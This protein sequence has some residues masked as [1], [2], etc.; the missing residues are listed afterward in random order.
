MSGTIYTIGHSTRTIAE[1]IA[2]LQQ[3]DVN[4][5]VD[6]R[7]FPRS[8]A[9]PQFN[10]DTLPDALAVEGIGYQHLRALG[11]RRHHPR[12][13]PS[14]KN[15]YWRVAAF[16]NYADYAETD[17]FRSGLDELLALAD[18]HRCA[19]MCAEAVWWRCHRR[20]ITDYLLAGS[21]PVE[22]IMGP[23]NVT[24][25]SMTPGAQVLADGTLHYP[26]AEGTDAASGES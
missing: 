24:P 19:I 4:L 12:G 25:A 8:R 6:V 3:V 11:G 17:A 1:F 18:N 9:M 22:H 2:L 26:P 21:V 13:A 10:F 5:L 14:S 23:A 16:R 7:S 20:I 15:T